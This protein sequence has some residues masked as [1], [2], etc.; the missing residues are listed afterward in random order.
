MAATLYSLA[1]YCLVWVEATATTLQATEQYV[2]TGVNNPRFLATA[3]QSTIVIYTAYEDKITK[4]SLTDGTLPSPLWIAGSGVFNPS[5]GSNAYQTTNSYYTPLATAVVY[6]NHNGYYQLTFKFP[7]DV[8]PEAAFSVT[9]PTN[10]KVGTAAIFAVSGSNLMTCTGS[11]AYRSWTC[12]APAGVTIP[13]GDDISISG[14]ATSPD[15]AGITGDFALRS[16]FTSTSDFLVT[17][18]LAAGT[19]V[20][21]DTAEFNVPDDFYVPLQVEFLDIPVRSRERGV[22]IVEFSPENPITYSAV[23]S[24]I[25]VQETSNK[26]FKYTPTAGA[27]DQAICMFVNMRTSE[28]YRAATCVSNGSGAFTARG[29]RSTQI[30][31]KQ[32]DN[33]TLEWWR[34]VIT[35]A[36]LE[37]QNNL[38]VV[39]N[40]GLDFPNVDNFNKRIYTLK[41]TIEG[42]K[43]CEESLFIPGNSPT[44]ASIKLISANKGFK[45]NVFL[46]TLDASYVA[47]SYTISL[48]FPA[49]IGAIEAFDFKQ[50]DADL[51]TDYGCKYNSAAPI[52]APC[53]LASHGF[54]Y[55]ET[56]NS[57]MEI[58]GVRILADPT[59]IAIPGIQN[60][61][62]EVLLSMDLQVHYVWNDVTYI[63]YFAR[64]QYVAQISNTV[65]AG[66]TVINN[67]PIDLGDL[68]DESWVTLNLSNSPLI[69]IPSGMYAYVKFTEVINTDVRLTDALFI[70]P[71]QQLIIVKATSNQV[72]LELEYLINPVSMPS[73]SSSITVTVF[74]ESSLYVADNVFPVSYTLNEFDI[75]IEV[76]S[77]DWD[78]EL[79]GGPLLQYIIWYKLRFSISGGNPILLRFTFPT[80]STMYDCEVPKPFTENANGSKEIAVMDDDLCDVLGASAN[81]YL[82]GTLD[83]DDWYYVSVWAKV[84]AGSDGVFKAQIFSDFAGTS[85]KA[86]SLSTAPISVLDF[87]PPETLSTAPYLLYNPTT[88]LRVG[89]IDNLTVKLSVPVD[90]IAN[91]GKVELIVDTAQIDLVTAIVAPY[92]LVGLWTDSSGTTYLSSDCSMATNMITVKAPLIQNLAAGTWTLQVSSTMIPIGP[93]GLQYAASASEKTVTVKIYADGSFKDGQGSAV[94]KLAPAQFATLML[95]S[96][97]RTINKPTMM[98][99]DFASTDS[100]T[101]GLEA[102]GGDSEIVLTFSYTLFGENFGLTVVNPANHNSDQTDCVA[103]VGLTGVKCYVRKG[104]STRHP[105]FVLRKYAAPATTAQSLLIGPIYNPS[106]EN[107][108]VHVTLTARSY[109]AGVWAT[110]GY[111]EFRNVYM[112]ADNTI[113]N[114]AGSISA[115]SNIVQASTTLTFTLGVDPGKEPDTGNYGMLLFSIEGSTTSLAEATLSAGGTLHILSINRLLVVFSNAPYAG[116]QDIETLLNNNYACTQAWSWNLYANGL[117]NYAS[118]AQNVILPTVTITPT[119]ASLVGNDSTFAF[120]RF[121]PNLYIIYFKT[122][123]AIPLGGEIRVTIPSMDVPTI[124]SCHFEGL[125]TAACSV[126]DSTTIN[127]TGFSA[128]GGAVALTV[129]AQVEYQTASTVNASNLNFAIATYGIAGNLDTGIETSSNIA[130]S[131]GLVATPISSL[132]V[133]VPRWY[134]TQTSATYSSYTDLSFSLVLQ[135]ALP[136]GSYIEVKAGSWFVAPGLTLRCAFSDGV[137]TVPAQQVDR[138]GVGGLDDCFYTSIT[139]TFTVK[140]QAQLPLATNTAYTLNL[141]FD[142]HATPANNG[143]QVPAGLTSATAYGLMD[144]YLTTKDSSDVLLNVAKLLRG[145]QALQLG[146]LVAKMTTICQGK[147]T[148]LDFKVES[149]ASASRIDLMFPTT[150]GLLASPTANFQIFADDFGTGLSSGSSL[151][152]ED[153]VSATKPMCILNRGSLTAGTHTVISIFPT[154]ASTRFRLILGTLE[155]ARDLKV[156]SNYK[157]PIFPTLNFISNLKVVA[158]DELNHYAF[159][160]NE[161]LLRNWQGT[162]A[163]KAIKFDNCPSAP[164]L[165]A[166][167]TLLPAA[168]DF[169]AGID[170]AAA[171]TTLEMTGFGSGN[172]DEVMGYII[173]VF[174]TPGLVITAE[175]R[176][177]DADDSEVLYYT[178]LNALIL[179]YTALSS[180]PHAAII[181]SVTNPKFTKTSG[182][183]GVGYLIDNTGKLK[184]IYSLKYPSVVPAF[185]TFAVSWTNNSPATTQW[186]AGLTGVDTYQW[187]STTNP[188]PNPNLDTYDLWQVT[189]TPTGGTGLITEVQLTVPMAIFSFVH[190]P[191]KVQGLVPLTTAGISCSIAV[192]VNAVATVSNFVSPVEGDNSP[193]TITFEAKTKSVEAESI[194]EISVVIYLDSANNAQVNTCKGSPSITT[195]SISSFFDAWVTWNSKTYYDRTLY[196][197]QTGAL[198]L[199]LTPTQTL[200]FETSSVQVTFPSGFSLATGGLLHCE[201][202]YADLHDDNYPIFQSRAT[203][204]TLVP[205]CVWN[206]ATLTLS[207]P[208]S[209][210]IASEWSDTIDR[211]F[212]LTLT[213]TNAPGAQG[214]VLP[215]SAGQYPIRVYTYMEAVQKE[216]ALPILTVPG[217]PFPTSSFSIFSLTST[218]SSESVVKVKFTTVSAVPAGYVSFQN[219]IPQLSSSLILTLEIYE[220]Y[221]Y[222]LARTYTNG[223]QVPCVGVTGLTSPNSLICTF[224]MGTNT[225]SEPLITTPVRPQITVSNYN[226][227]SAS[228]NVELHLVRLINPATS[229]HQP[230][231]WVTLQ[232]IDYDGVVTYLELNNAPTRPYD[233]FAQAIADASMT[234]ISPNAAT[235]NLSLSV[236]VSGLSGNRQDFIC[237]GF[238]HWVVSVTPPVTVDLMNAGGV[239]QVGI[240]N[241][242]VGIYQH[243]R[244]IVAFLKPGFSVESAAG[245]NVEIGGLSAPYFNSCSGVACT[246]SYFA[247]ALSTVQYPRYATDPVAP[248]T[249][250]NPIVF[251]NAYVDGIG[252]LKLPIT[253]DEVMS[254]DNGDLFYVSFPESF[255]LSGTITAHVTDS[256]LNVGAFS[257]VLYASY[258]LLLVYLNAGSTVPSSAD[259]LV[260]SN[261]LNPPY[262][263]KG[264]INYWPIINGVNVYP[265]TSPSGVLAGQVSNIAITPS[266]LISNDVFVNYT[267]SFNTIPRI[268]AGSSLYFNF[269]S[270]YPQLSSRDLPA[271]C[272]TTLP[273]PCDIYS[274]GIKIAN[275][276]PLN[277]NSPVS[278][279][280]LG[281]KNPPLAGGANG[282]Q[283]LV[284]NANNN[285]VIDHTV[286]TVLTLKAPSA[287]PL[288]SLTLT[289]TSYTSQ[290][291]PFYTIT[292]NS[293]AVLYRGTYVTLTLPSGFTMPTEVMCSDLYMMRAYLGCARGN[294]NTIVL[295]LSSQLKGSFGLSVLGILNPTLT[296]PDSNGAQIF[297][298][299]IVTAVYDGTLLATTDNSYQLTIKKA[300]KEISINSQSLLP[301]NTAEQTLY[302]VSLTAPQAIAH[303][304]NYAF[305]FRFPMQFD[306]ALVPT[307]SPLYCHSSVEFSKCGITGA[308]EVQFW[309]FVNDVVQGE[310]LL[311]EIQGIVNPGVGPTDQVSIALLDLATNQAIAFSPNTATGTFLIRQSPALLKIQN[312]TV[313][314]SA[315]GAFTNLNFTID[316]GLSIFLTNGDLWINWPSDYDGFFNGRE[317]SC[318][319]TYGTLTTTNCTWPEK[320]FYKRTVLPLSY[321]TTRNSQEKLSNQVVNVMIKGV[322]NPKIRGM[323]GHFTASYVNKDT[324]LIVTTSF[325]NLDGISQLNIQSGNYTMSIPN[326]ADSITLTAGTWSQLLNITL[327]GGTSQPMKIVMSSDSTNLMFDPPQLQFQY[328]WNTQGS[329]RIGVK[330]SAKGGNYRVFFTK[331]EGTP[332]QLYGSLPDINVVVVRA[333]AILAISFDSIPPLPVGVVSQPVVVSLSQPCFDNFEVELY[334]TAP[335]QPELV[336]LTP[337]LLRFRAGDQSKSFTIALSNSAKPGQIGVLLRGSGASPYRAPAYLSFTVTEPP[338]SSPTVLLVNATFVGRISAQVEVRLSSIATVYYMYVLNGK[339]MPTPMQLSSQTPPASDIDLKMGQVST[340][341]NRFSMD[342]EQFYR[343]NIPME[344]LLD[345]SNYTLFI[346]YQGFDFKL[347]PDLVAVNITTKPS[348]PPVTFS[349]TCLGNCSIKKIR[350][351]LCDALAIPEVLLIYIGDDENILK[352]NRHLQVVTYPFVLVSDRTKEVAS[353]Q[354]MIQSLDAN[355]NLLLAFLPGLN[356]TVSLNQTVVVVQNSTPEV[357]GNPRITF[358]T[359][360]TMNVEVVQ[361]VA[362]ILFGVVTDST[363]PRPTSWQIAHGLDGNNKKVAPGLFASVPCLAQYLATLKFTSMKEYHR[364]HVWIT[365]TNSYGTDSQLMREE[366]VRMMVVTGGRLG[367]GTETQAVYYTWES[368]ALW[369][370]LLLAF[371]LTL[372]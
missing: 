83:S 232:T 68:G 147:S 161:M 73:G 22:L 27:G 155:T 185:C 195:S 204:R 263:S 113:D 98:I 360:S 160:I 140:V 184:N 224:T 238:Q 221:A 144:F 215:S 300:P 164:T 133:V 227:I 334:S 322:Q 29:P 268:S 340:G 175:D 129:Q 71:S 36:G 81:F 345:G 137:N 188:N 168:P 328:A 343:V 253:L 124:T 329:F 352:R 294:G 10:Y 80:G 269:P 287:P 309:G 154:A 100:L 48:I 179:D 93:E 177:S 109:S 105:E 276:G 9:F 14:R 321:A 275:V 336:K 355:L 79:H 118:T 35:T 63:Q 64:L 356:T 301:L 61:A 44:A 142:H 246:S 90:L 165:P 169:V 315:A 186:S 305:S 3:E 151:T 89:A 295:R 123:L 332:V 15:T 7:S 347:S 128:I 312:I 244:M 362:G 166:L 357:I 53:T 163:S 210:A 358:V 199:R 333:E 38:G 213:S 19:V 258:S 209:S 87:T 261:L 101:A 112:T 318:L 95:T 148:L 259:Y 67:T 20:V 236:P 354:S 99:L 40:N 304:A 45:N 62:N 132:K 178:P 134:G 286:L 214:F 74:D 6:K 5:I 325:G 248:T 266:S 145:V 234:S 254:G 229:R 153:N 176:F 136:L 85:Q 274:Y 122:T 125:L 159:P 218:A 138:D 202:A 170:A 284:K 121:H 97:S 130:V 127:L 251:S 4:I 339:P 314:D 319:A 353:P 119:A 208:F 110:T 282:F 306:P 180:S 252:T 243:S 143:F 299:F 233:P 330:S 302:T 219:N 364:Y 270:N 225:V 344:E 206:A 167:P 230:Q 342:S 265:H 320:Y 196:A 303:G 203:Q 126:V 173:L 181:D 54:V 183:G 346:A 103:L 158:Y 50:G 157:N 187:D 94:L 116:S 324:S 237:I 172:L 194:G 255:P 31:P 288:M 267:V 298:P 120:G 88:V 316:L 212:W 260:L 141:Y 69:T 11:V 52:A 23:P 366:D 331:Y 139:K 257:T 55:T 283:V 216:T 43:N 156:P 150:N 108:V 189:I 349:I 278:I 193:F 240:G 228:V 311:F 293:P 308:R 211:C 338:T 361:T 198:R 72:T 16:Y 82:Y 235:M 28:Q 250:M 317:M 149:T 117:L 271:S 272:T 104:S 33:V 96:Y 365:G 41:I 241:F 59:E 277:T 280:I 297:G 171:S 115:D 217:Q 162:S 335:E 58:T 75:E 363:S 24:F 226:A 60:P 32:S 56:R 350:K 200:D 77:L 13:G 359:N 17:E 26:A 222:E 371:W 2:L 223:S 78:V 337:S 313:D 326:I 247:T 47:S 51:G 289:S 341:S 231:I 197:G 262:L 245:L 34:L 135:D 372:A 351:A 86:E 146:T 285:I 239:S 273:V 21:T 12:T 192:G 370:G 65:A 114:T 207:V 327:S 18:N 57:R 242:E 106:A 182:Y 368:K 307:T 8:S 367:H 131:L 348:F 191:C 264:N 37:S 296:S 30:T 49:K 152:C 190:S 92:R 201:I 25:T 310:F 256:E 369:R 1:P 290:M 174:Q 84:A 42:G 292:M 46:L 111:A 281:V 91:T 220:S 205:G 107:K 66:N 279:S 291:A 323:T 39:T 76:P 70:L 249:H 102:V